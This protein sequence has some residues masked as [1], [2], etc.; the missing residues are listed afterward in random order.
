MKRR[1][2]VEWEQEFP[3]HQSAPDGGSCWSARL[4]CGHLVREP[5]GRIPNPG[6]WRNC[7]E[8]FRTAGA[9]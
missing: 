8:C 9:S 7:P 6:A 3:A 1:K 4:T 2:V 5:R